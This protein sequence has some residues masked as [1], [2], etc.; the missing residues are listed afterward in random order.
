M[1]YILTNCLI[2]SLILQL[3]LAPVSAAEK[4][5]PNRSR[6]KLQ[7]IALP[8]EVGDIGKKSGAIYY[9][10]SVKGKV[11]IPV[12]FWGEVKNTGLHFMPQETTLIDGISLAGGPTATGKLDNVKLV[13]KASDGKIDTMEFDLSKGG[14]QNAYLHKLA[15]SDTVFIEKST[16]YEDRTYYTSL[17]GVAATILSSIL[18][19]REV[20]K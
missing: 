12:H 8:S 1:R 7:E 14:D 6:L 16:F 19:L 10:P 18:L 20:R 5:E 2:A 9:N 11:L 15:P 3:G 17:I 4:N 13:K